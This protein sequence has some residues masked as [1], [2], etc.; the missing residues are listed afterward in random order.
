MFARLAELNAAQRGL[1]DAE[2]ALDEVIQM[3]PASQD[4]PPGGTRDEAVV[5]S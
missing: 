1:T 3:Y 2:L 4:V 5:A